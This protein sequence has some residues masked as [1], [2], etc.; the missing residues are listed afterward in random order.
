MVTP[1]ISPAAKMKGF[2]KIVFSFYAYYNSY[3]VYSYRM[4]ELAIFFIQGS[5][6]AAKVSVLLFLL[7]MNLVGTS[8]YLVVN[9]LQESSFVYILGYIL[10]HSL[11]FCMRIYL[12]KFIIFVLE[13]QSSFYTL[14]SIEFRLRWRVRSF[15]LQFFWRLGVED[16]EFL[17]DLSK[18]FSLY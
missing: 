1:D 18:T 4:I 12:C 16:C 11:R 7:S 8:K 2:L 5:L 9:W 15:L 6:V 10:G 14:Y 17:R 13:V 3:F